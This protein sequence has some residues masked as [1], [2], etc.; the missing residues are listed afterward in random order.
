MILTAPRDWPTKRLR[1]VTRRSLTD[2]QRQLL[3]S[4]LQVTFLP[5][6]AIGEQGELDLSAVRDIEDVRTG[7]TPFFDG[8]VLIAKITPCFENGKGALVYG[9][10]QGVGFGTTELHVLRPGPEVNGRFLYYVTASGPFRKLGEADMTGAAGQ[11]RV[12][13]DFVRDF[14]VPV[15]PI[16]QQRAIAV[17]LDRETARLDALV[18]AKE[19]LL[20]LLAEKRRAL[21]TRTVTRGLDPRVPLRDSGIPWLGEIPAHWGLWKVGHLATIGNG[22]TPNRDNA[23]YWTDGLIPWLNSS[24]VNQDEV[25]EANQFITETGFRESHLPLVKSGSILVGITG[26]GKTR[27]QA[28]VLSFEATINQHLAFITPNE[29]AADPWFLRWVF[30]AAYDFLRS[31]SDDAGGTKGAL[32]CEDVAAM[33]VPLPPIDE[34][35][36]I[37]TYIAAETAKLHAL[38]SATERTTA[39]LKERRAALIAAAVTGKIDAQGAGRRVELVANI[40]PRVRWPSSEVEERPR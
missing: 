33:R 35:R 23:E 15:P 4:A 27:G 32:T 39:L 21:I 29:D 36:T 37:A 30:F 28:V 20:G 22:S 25:T 13:E 38:R 8:D 10:L 26:Q 16:H 17:Y 1:F 3:S 34:Q 14:R 24:V 6:E 31:I 19:R 18:A 12:P 7:Y 40:E 9:T 11:K 5:M 2:D